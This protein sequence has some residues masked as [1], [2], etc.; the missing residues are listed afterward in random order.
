M[1]TKEMNIIE[2]V[3]KFPESVE[4]F[5]SYGMGCFGCMAARFETL[6]QGALAHG[7]DV[8]SLVADLNEAIK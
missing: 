3:E 7:L 1:I 2:I 5:T 4:V 8:D 6:E